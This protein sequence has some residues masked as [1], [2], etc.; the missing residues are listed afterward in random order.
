MAIGPTAAN[1]VNDSQD[2]LPRDICDLE[3]PH[4]EQEIVLRYRTKTGGPRELGSTVITHNMTISDGQ[5][6]HWEYRAQS[7]QALCSVLDLISVEIRPAL[8]L[9]WRVEGAG[10]FYWL[11]HDNWTRDVWVAA[12]F[13]QEEEMKPVCA[14]LNRPGLVAVKI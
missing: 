10:T 1:D 6:R 11:N 9:A 2:P 3:T 7:P 4:Y 5:V 12:R 14:V 13:N 8:V